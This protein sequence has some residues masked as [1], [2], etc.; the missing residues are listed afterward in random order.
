VLPNP[1]AVV[2][3]DSIA[4]A[5]RIIRPYIRRTPVKLESLQHT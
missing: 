2:D 1:V 5:E 4:A 3:A